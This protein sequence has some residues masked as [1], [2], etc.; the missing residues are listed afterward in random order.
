MKPTMKVIVDTS[1]DSGALIFYEEI[2]FDEEL[3]FECDFLCDNGCSA[4]QNPSTC[5]LNTPG[6]EH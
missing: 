5:P 3:C 6:Y 1:I 2:D 4:G